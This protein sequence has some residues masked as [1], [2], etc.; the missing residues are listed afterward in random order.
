VADLGSDFVTRTKAT[1]RVFGDHV[2]PDAITANVGFPADHQHRVGDFIGSSREHRYKNNMWLSTSKSP[3]EATLEVHINE[4][5]SRVEPK[6]AYFRSLAE[7]ATVDLYC[8]IFW[9]TGFQVSSQTISR[10]GAL[11]AAFGVTIYNSD[12]AASGSDPA[13]SGE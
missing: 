11:G 13:V 5:L 4:L 2:D 1:L 7:H 6:D 3:P 8:T 9:H 10:I 12:S